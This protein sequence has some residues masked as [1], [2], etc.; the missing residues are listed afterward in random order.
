[1]GN[2]N[3]SKDYEENKVNIIICGDIFCEINKQMINSI[4]ENAPKNYEFK[5]MIDLKENQ[6][7]LYFS[8]EI[9]EGEITVKL[10]E[11]I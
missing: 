4:F 3:D 7:Y 1:M 10:M 6:E 2:N 8:G 9:I 11:Q 5:K